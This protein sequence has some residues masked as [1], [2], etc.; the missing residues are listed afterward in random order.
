MLQERL[1]IEAS[2]PK[3]LDQ[4]RQRI[5]TKHYSVRTEQAYLQRIKR[6]VLFQGKREVKQLGL[7]KRIVKEG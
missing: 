2:K 3:L 4:V 6:F 7:K 5:R 1:H